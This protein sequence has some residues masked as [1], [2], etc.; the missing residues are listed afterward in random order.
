MTR[1]CSSNL[2]PATSQIRLWSFRSLALLL[3]PLPRTPAPSGFFREHFAKA[4]AKAVEELFARFD[5][6][7]NEVEFRAGQD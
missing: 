5:R 2:H 6:F 7:L 4:K 1:F 3:F